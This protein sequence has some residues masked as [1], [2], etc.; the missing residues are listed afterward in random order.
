MK[1]WRTLMPPDR[2]IE[3]DYET[4][5]DDLAGEAK[6]LIQF[7]G[8]TWDEACLN[9][10]ETRRSVRTASVNQVRQP[11]YK[12]SKGRWRAHAKHL[13]PLLSALGVTQ[14]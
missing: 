1:H 6:R 13:A 2:F 14:E 8:L 5:V 7:I 12:T 11:I 10:H 3:V 9:F 4:V